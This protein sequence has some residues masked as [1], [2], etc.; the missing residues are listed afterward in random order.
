[1]ALLLCED[2]VAKRYIQFFPGA[3]S[4]LGYDTNRH[5]KQSSW[6]TSVFPRTEITVSLKESCSNT[7]DFRLLVRCSL[8]LSLMSFCRTVLYQVHLHGSK[9]KVGW[10]QSQKQ[11]RSLRWMCRFSF[12]IKAQGLYCLNPAVLYIYSAALL[13]YLLC[14]LKALQ[15][16]LSKSEAT[17]E[18]LCCILFYEFFL[19]AQRQIEIEMPSGRVEGTAVRSSLGAQEGAS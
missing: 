5:G 13:L 10:F 1:M 18:L 15:S 4:M 7:G 12:C 17:S 19:E 8:F 9:G 16:T 14:C 11:Q 3:F 2:S 6:V